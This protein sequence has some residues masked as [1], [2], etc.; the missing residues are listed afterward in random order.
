MADNK[1]AS[2]IETHPFC[3]LYACN[4]SLSEHNKN[5]TCKCLKCMGLHCQGCQQYMDLMDEANKND[6]IKLERC[7]SCQKQK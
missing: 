1:E 4:V 5:G 2:W 6:W 7:I 3:G